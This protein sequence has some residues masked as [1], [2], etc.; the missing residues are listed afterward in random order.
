VF[1]AA[2]LVSCMLLVVADSIIGHGAMCCLWSY[3]VVGHGVVS[4]FLLEL[5]VVLLSF[6][7]AVAFSV[8]VLSCLLSVIVSLQYMY[9]FT[10]VLLGLYCFTCCWLVYRS[11]FG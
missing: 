9:C 10:C 11:G 4:L 5:A 2:G 6:L 7:I 3:G 1:V 8:W